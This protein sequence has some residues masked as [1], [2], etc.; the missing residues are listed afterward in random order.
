MGNRAVI[1]T[2]PYSGNN[3]GIYLHW[4][5]GRA[6]VEAFLQAAK[7]LGYRSPGYGSDS[8]GIAGLAGLIWA[9]LATDG[10]S[11]GIGLC[12]HLDTD[13]GDN[14]TYLIG[15]DWEIVGRKFFDGGREEINPKKTAQI[16]ADVLE[17]VAAAENAKAPVGEAE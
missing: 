5:G 11:A 13:N 2:A 1:T 9:Y 12:K 14:G 10:L 3:V 15:K 7:D 6:S 8:Y 4:N 16:K 17:K